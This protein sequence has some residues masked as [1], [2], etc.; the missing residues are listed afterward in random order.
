[1]GLLEDVRILAKRGF[2]P[3]EDSC[4]LVCEL[5]GGTCL[6]GDGTDLEH[7]SNCSW[8][9]MPKIVAALEA[10]GDLL[11]ASDRVSRGHY[12]KTIKNGPFKRPGDPDM[13]QMCD[14]YCS[15]WPCDA[16][17]ME[18]SADMLRALLDGDSTAKERH[19]D[20]FELIGR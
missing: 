19:L 12:A 6:L 3:W 17:K 20:G 2:T 7:K 15:T 9:A 8:L 13:I 5:C 18:G 14:S 4:H 16:A 10:A 1:M 11:V